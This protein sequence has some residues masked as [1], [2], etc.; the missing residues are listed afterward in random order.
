MKREQ[1]L[2]KIKMKTKTH[3]WIYDE[4][5]SKKYL[6]KKNAIENTVCTMHM[7]QMMVLTSFLFGLVSS[8]CARGVFLHSYAII[9][10]YTEANKN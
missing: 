2:V 10:K 7:Q 1:K 9:I 8:T 4:E 3:K 5:K 6:K